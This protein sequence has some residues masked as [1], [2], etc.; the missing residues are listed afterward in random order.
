MT[1]IARLGDSWSGKC[2]CHHSPISVTGTI[3]TGSSDHFS[4]GLPVARIGDTVKATC[5]HTGKIVSGSST[6]FT[7][8]VEKAHIGSETDGICLVGVIVTGNPT[9]IID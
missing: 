3:I 5:G 2:L 1:E 4:G 8:I 9:H 6:D 7:N